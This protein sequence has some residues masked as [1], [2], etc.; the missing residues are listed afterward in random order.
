MLSGRIHT[1]STQTHTHSSRT[2]SAA[3]NNMAFT[4][5]NDT[6]TSSPQAKY[7]PSTD[8]VVHPTSGKKANTQHENGLTRTPTGQRSSKKKTHQPACCRR[9][10]YVECWTKRSNLF[11]FSKHKASPLR[12]LAAV[13][14]IPSDVGV[15]HVCRHSPV[16]FVHRCK[17]VLGGLE[18][19]WMTSQTKW[20]DLSRRVASCTELSHYE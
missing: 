9:R 12:K 2:A 5:T 17:T 18:W 3:Q 19:C 4:Q 6:L 15:S 13:F 1:D 14:A 7:T 20:D 8:C 16:Q 11:E 10:C